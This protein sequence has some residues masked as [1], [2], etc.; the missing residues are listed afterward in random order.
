MLMDGY[1]YGSLSMTAYTL[2]LQVSPAHGS[3]SAGAIPAGLPPRA[4]NM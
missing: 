2:D 4:T 1:A 3:G